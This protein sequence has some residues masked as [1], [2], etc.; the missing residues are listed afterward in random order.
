MRNVT[1]TNIETAACFLAEADA[2][3]VAA[4]AGMGVDSGLARLQ[5]QRRLLEGVPRTCG[6]SRMDFT[7]IAN[8]GSL[9]SPP[10][11]LAWGFYG[12]RLKLYR[13]IR[14]HAGFDILKTFGE[15]KPNGWAVFTSNVDGQFQKAGLSMDPCMNATAPSITSSVWS[16]AAAT[17]GLLITSS[18]RSMRSTAS[19]STSLPVVLAMRRS[20][21]AQHP[22]VR[23]HGA[24]WSQTGLPSQEQALDNVGSMR[25]AAS[26]GHRTGGRHGHCVGPLFQPACSASV[27]R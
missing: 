9:P 5:G 3:V 20:G 18:R 8:P 11:T 10:G 16:H 17:S 7:C 13:G 6:K 27:P 19:C 1:A 22:D 24:G 12:H 2:I 25:T 21:P 15:T 14:P 4:G 26:G 23:R